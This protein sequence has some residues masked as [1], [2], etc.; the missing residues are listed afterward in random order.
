MG[1]L[2]EGVNSRIANFKEIYNFKFIRKMKKLGSW[3]WFDEKYVLT[4]RKKSSQ[5]PIR[6]V[7]TYFISN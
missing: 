6:N 7:K 1:R 5:A 2:A 3:I 4:L